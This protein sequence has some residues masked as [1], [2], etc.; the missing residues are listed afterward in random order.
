MKNLF[1]TLIIL[2]CL[3]VTGIG[4]NGHPVKLR[5]AQ[6]PPAVP[7]QVI[8]RF[9]SLVSDLLQEN[10]G[11]VSYEMTV[12]WVH[13]RGQWIVDATIT[14]TR[15]SG[16]FIHAAYRQNGNLLEWSYYFL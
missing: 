1:T 2:V 16:I 12:E 14:V 4:A 7:A 10:F 11:E 3:T 8:S 9:E 15:S 6:N 13:Y 5:S